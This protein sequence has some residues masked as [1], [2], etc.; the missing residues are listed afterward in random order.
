MQAEPDQPARY[1]PHAIERRWQQIWADERTWEVPNPGEP[2]FDDSKPKAYVLE[3][4]PYPSG[5]PHVGHLKNYSLGDA[6]A[7][8]RRR[9][10]FQVIHPMGYDAFGLPA[11][12]H[13]IKTGEHP[14]KAVEASIAA[15]SEQFRAWGVSIDWS[16]EIATHEPEYYRWTQWI[17]L[18]LFERGLAYRSE[19]P[20]KWCPVDQTVLANEQV[21]DGHCERCGSLVESR[22]L[23]QWFFKITEYAD[24]LL[25]DFEQLESWPEH[26]VTMQRNWIGRSEGAEV[27]FRCEE[28]GIDFPVFTT[29]PDTLF[30]ATF[31]VL[32]PEHPDVERLAA[33]TG[34][35]QEVRAYVDAAIRES[36]EERGDEAREKTGV[37]LG[38]TV[39][40]P[41]NGEQIP[42]FVSDYVLME[43][44]TGALM[45]VPAHDQ[46]DHDFA[47]RYKLPIVE[48][49][50]GGEDVQAEPFIG[51]GPMVNSGRFDGLNNRKAYAAIV[52][53]LESEG[54]GSASVNYRLRDWLLSRQRYWGCP[55]PIVY[56]EGCGMVEVPDDQLPVELPEVEDYAPKGKSPLAAVEDWVNTE[57]PKCGGPAT[58]ETDTMDTFV[59]SSW[60]FLRYLDPNNTELPFAR[61]VVDFWMPV[62]NYIGGVEHAIL[63][64][65]YARFFTKALSDMGMLSAQEPFA[66]LFTQGMITMDGAKMSSSKGNT[67]SAV[68]TVDRYGADTARA[69]VCFLGPPERGGDWVPEGVEGVH[70]FLVRLWRLSEE[71]APATSP[72]SPPGVPGAEPEGAALELLRKAHWAIDKVTRDIEDGFQL[73]TAISAVMELVNDAYRLKGDL[74]GDPAGDAA[75]RFATATAASLIFPFAPHLGCEVY[76]AIT[77]DRVWERPWPQADASLLV[78]DQITVVIQVNGKRR[79]QIVVSA[80]TPEEEL[81][82]LAR[83]SENVIRHLDGRR[84]VKEIVV[85]GK[86]VN[87]VVG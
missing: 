30:G 32:A 12:N 15:Y 72:A 17:F 5:E 69:Y 1:E 70:R 10:G 7:H 2:G 40:N 29:R 46:R 13:A 42:M 26:V 23:E 80:D 74:Y 79:D 56:C 66:S 20:V 41:V 14:R 53:W 19:A 43:Y 84:I 6:I 11:E 37:P 65:M 25:S 57:C 50:A 64:L 3:M 21:I 76:D 54:K 58:R 62:D 49:V 51:D 81:L 83:A 33:G 31:F 86:L 71:V 85:P 8:F 38:R 22:N 48:V 63:H 28:L 60:Y 39:T 75:L 47:S 34:R 18:R 68:E 73:H 55:I 77:G 67:V 36:V 45:A 82:T 24:R 78:R 16:R 52:E 87:L 4:L 9:N 61:E 35:E 44:G 59:D 27:T